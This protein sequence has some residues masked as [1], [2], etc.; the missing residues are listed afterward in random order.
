[1]FEQKTEDQIIEMGKA[2]IANASHELRT[3]ITIIRG[4]A[5]TLQDFPD[6]PEETRK[7]IIEKIVRTCGRLEKLVKS[8]LTLSDIE[9]LSEEA[10]R[11]YD[12]LKIAET[13]KNQLLIACPEVQIVICNKCPSSLVKVEPDLL[14]LA[15]MNLLENAVRYSRGTA[16]IEI[17]LR[18]LQSRIALEIADKGMGI[19]QDDLP[20]IFDRFYT[21]NKAHSRKLGGAGL[22]LSI[23]KTIVDKH[24]G[25]CCVS[26]KLGKGSTFSLIFPNPSSSVLDKN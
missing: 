2:F 3:P 22:G 14:E 8:L 11:S 18:K 5:E 4:F 25:E 23:V 9:H 17:T 20:L 10:F 1:M 19:P 24:K 12:L 6:L 26:S 13:C 15:V 7:M 16:Q 21:V